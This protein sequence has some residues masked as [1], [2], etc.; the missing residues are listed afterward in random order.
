ME[1][2]SGVDG[3]QYV[4]ITHDVED[5]PKWKAIFDDA[6][7]IRREAGEI[8]YQLLALENSATRIVHFSRWT[9]LDAART[10]FESPRLVEIRRDAGVVA[11]EFGYLMQLEAGEL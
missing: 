2:M 3:G 7:Q 9:S 6:A 1:R 8:E 11:P 10:F 4:L 5:Y